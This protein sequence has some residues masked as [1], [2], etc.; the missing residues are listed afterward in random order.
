[1][2]VGICS[3]G[4]ELLTGDQVD[5]NAAW[6]AGRLR[7]VGATAVL[8]MAVR[9][10]LDEMVDALRLLLDRCDGVV[11]GGGLGPTPDDL[12]REAVARVAGVALEHRDDLEEMIVQKF[13]ALGARMSPNNL[14]QARVPAG[15]VAWEPV[16]TAP[17]FA[18]EVDGRPVWVLPGVPWELQAMFDEHVV[19]DLLAR[20]GGQTTVTR[21]VHVTGL[22]ESHVADALTGVEQRA[23]ATGVEVAYL[24]TRGEILVKLTAH[25]PDRDAAMTAGQ[26]WV[27][28]VTAVLG[29]AVAG[30]DESSVEQ[31]VHHLLHDA[32]QTVAIAESATAGLVCARLAS[33]PGTSTTLRGGA[34]VYATDTKVDVLGI[35]HGLLAEH[36]P[37][38][39]EVTVGLAR[40]VRETFGSHWGVATTGVAGPSDQDGVPVGTCVWAVCGPDGSVDVHERVI[41]GDRE[42]VRARLTTVALDL[43]RR[44]L[45]AAREG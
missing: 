22:G 17:A 37:V 8:T 45:L 43:L 14:Q 27:D 32:G 21:V 7:E 11:V 42:T 4:T 28:E 12:T 31:S 44:R 36:P 6:V 20:T 24:A 18:L 9:D 19:P 1:M 38:S 41:P 29:V 15:A 35:D 34:V 13:A 25:G 26:A 10:D 39:R 3:V 23:E 40:A 2:R 16:G 30:V 33:V 5:S